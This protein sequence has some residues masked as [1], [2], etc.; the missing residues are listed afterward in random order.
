M[1]EPRGPR[2]SSTLEWRLYLA[3]ALAGVYLLTWRAIVWSASSPSSG[4]EPGPGAVVQRDDAP[5]SRAVWL[6]DLPLAERPSIAVPPGWEIA[7][8]T[9]P[10]VAPTP[11]TPPRVVRAPSSRPRRVRTRS[12]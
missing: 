1:T 7:S 5:A 10:E 4:G 2:R 6:D 12:S 3:S 9:A 11:R 8:R